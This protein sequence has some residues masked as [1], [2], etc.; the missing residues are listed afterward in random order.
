MNLFTKEYNQFIWNAFIIS[1]VEKYKLLTYCEMLQ[2]LLQIYTVYVIIINE[3]IY[4]YYL[5]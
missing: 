2:N 4:V 5:K 3:N 1:K